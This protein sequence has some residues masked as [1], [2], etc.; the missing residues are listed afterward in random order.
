MIPSKKVKKHKE[1]DN[2]MKSKVLIGLLVLLI[3]CLSLTGCKERIPVPPVD[4]ATDI[5]KLVE[6]GM[7]LDQVYGLM[8]L[9]LKNS[10][11]LYQAQTIQK[12]LSGSWKIGSVEGGLTEES[13]APYGV[14]IFTPDVAGEDVYMIFF[15][16]AAVIG[17][18][19]FA[20]NAADSIQNLLEGSLTAD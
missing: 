8:N 20:P 16:N 4:R 1:G 19:W 17:S 13:E 14:L 9:Q 6:E 3:A 18:D 15:Q 12:Q 7:T 10:T 2:E 11:T 5:A